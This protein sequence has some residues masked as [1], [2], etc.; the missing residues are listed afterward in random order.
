[1]DYLKILILEMN[2]LNVKVLEKLEINLT[3]VLVGLSDLLKLCLIESA[4]VPD[5][6]YKLKFLLKIYYLVVPVFSLV[7]MDV[8]EVILKVLGP[9]S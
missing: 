9:I 4:S 3:V 2:G 8:M 5:K 6:F 1:M 7:V